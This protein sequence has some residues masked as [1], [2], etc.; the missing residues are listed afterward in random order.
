MRWTKAQTPQVKS[1][2][3][4]CLKRS[5]RVKKLIQSNTPALLSRLEDPADFYHFPLLLQSFGVKWR[6]LG[7][8]RRCLF[9]MAFSCPSTMSSERVRMYWPWRGEPIILPVYITV[10]LYSIALRYIKP[11][12]FI[13]H[14]Y[15]RGTE[16]SNTRCELHWLYLTI[17]E[18]IL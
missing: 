16:T 8:M 14:F 7:S 13:F 15:L 12:A 4:V 2:F 3:T 10:H 11:L 9:C 18:W 5:P 1:M 17:L 6:H